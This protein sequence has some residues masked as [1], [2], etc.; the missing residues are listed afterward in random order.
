MAHPQ[1][2]A[3]ARLADGGATT[4]RRLEGQS[5]F[6]GRTMHSI[7]YDEVHD[8]IVVPQQFAQAILTFRGSANGDEPA[9]RVIQGSKTQLKRPDRITVDPVHNEIFVPDG[10]SVMVYSREAHGNVAP[11]RILKGP[12]TQLGGG[13]VAVDPIN[14]LLVVAGSVGDWGGEEGDQ[15]L[16]FDRTAEGNAKPL[17]V[18]RGPHTMLTNTKNVRVYPPRGWILVAE[19]GVE[20]RA[21]GLS[22]VGVWSIQDD[23][24][25]PPRWTIGGP[26]GALLKPRGVALDPK[27]RA[28][29]VSD[30]KL[31][32]VLT[33]YLPEIF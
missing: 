23:G 4:T 24:D 31:N 13:A 6:L 3:F 19:D 20:G 33:Y 7:D 32:A 30:K 10:G 26:K 18:I 5:T 11:I 28:V 15:L 2:A 1:I 8:E 29:I 17:R 12:D 22:F 14:N 21:T 9:I 16:I 25:V 27:N